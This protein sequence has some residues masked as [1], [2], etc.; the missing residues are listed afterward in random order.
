MSKKELRISGMHCSSCALII[1]KK[2]KKIP[3]VKSAVVNYAN[4]KAVVEY[5]E[6]VKKGELEDS[7]KQSGYGV[8][9]YNNTKN[10]AGHQHSKAPGA[11]EANRD[12]NYFLVS[13]V[14]AIPVF[15]LSMVMMSKGIENKI[16]QLVLAGIVQFVLGARFYRGAFYALKNKTANMDTLVALGTS[17]AYFY[18]IATTFFIAGDVFF[19]TS[20]LL[21]TFI[22]LG[23][24]LESRA[25][26]KTGEA[27][28]KLM[29]LGAKTARI[30]VDGQEKDVPIEQVKV[31]DIILVRPGE[32]IPV[33]GEIIDGHSSIDE[34]M[35]TGES[36]PVE[37]KAGDLVIGAT[38]NK[39]GSFKFKATKVG[40]DT[41]LSQI[42]QFV[43]NAQ[44]SKAP[45][46]KFAD[47]V[48]SYFVPT[49]VV[50]AIITFLIWYFLIGV[51]FVKALMIFT[52]VLVIAC[53]CALGLATPTA[54]MV[55]TGKGAESGIL[56]KGGEYLEIANK[57]QVVVFDK[58][59]TLTKGEPEVTEIK[60]T[61]DKYKRTDI[62]GIA[63]SLEKN[64]EHPLAESI[65]NKA[66]EEKISL[67]EP[68]EFDAIVG[69]GVKGRINGQEVLIGT[70]KLML[71]NNILF[72]EKV[73]KQK[74][75]LEDQG[76]TVM[77]IAIAKEVAGLIAVADV[78]KETSRQSIEK[79]REM[80]IETVMLTGDN[81]RTAE[82]IGNQ[83]GI[84][85]VLAQVMPEEKAQQIKK[86]Q[87][88]GKMVAMVGDGI[89]DA[90]ALA[91]ADLG[92]AM[93]AG[94]DIAI[95]T[96]GIVLVKNDLNDAVRS[97]KLSKMTLSKIKQNMFWA[98]FYNSIGI[99][100]AALG[101]LRA[102][103]AGL[104][105]A[106]SSVSVVMN[107]L[108]LKRKKLK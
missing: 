75:E 60:M 79:L 30:I 80:G 70:E 25:K 69:M 103:F 105:M 67:T 98:L 4:E 73:R 1:E 84:D 2:L 64:S 96:G 27:I 36:I 28:K 21:I 82:A 62:L 107:S 77:I 93:G 34:A 17:A 88:E 37:K 39:T 46:Q 99:P 56:I 65:V 15:I 89:N 61:N 47:M 87:A 55:G 94:T 97:I 40:A 85:K 86:L 7:I 26:G 44:G 33:D 106:L 51:V 53:P 9:E 41:M 10:N 19:E 59:G 72:D 12:R 49:V 43:Q 8:D 3:G 104:A 95:E 13:L 81:Q 92:I 78:V 5:S 6:E 102:E 20:A 90:P 108:L 52:A 16:A 74:L 38:I 71:Q 24:W 48:S 100:I 29:E 23:K 31:G 35:V 63:A 42:I 32:K 22:L 18:S 45:I 50:I 14:I 91:Q 54:I 101:L 68:G 58:T 57:V 66:K 76:K 83:V 11:R